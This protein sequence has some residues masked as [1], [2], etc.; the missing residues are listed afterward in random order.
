MNIEKYKNYLILKNELNSQLNNFYHRPLFR[1]LK[2]RRYCRTKSADD[3]FLNE[4]QEKFGTNLLIGLG[5]WSRTMSMKGINSTP[6]KYLTNLLSKRFDIILVNE[7]RTSKLYNKDLT[8]EL[9]NHKIKNKSIH[10]LLTPTR[11][12]T[13]VIVNRDRNACK[14]ILNILKSHIHFGIRPNEFCRTNDVVN[15]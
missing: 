10:M 12:P 15:L 13:G 14:N 1:K 6:N 8:I 11:K 4:I 9:K 7:F 3:Q 5:D 2:F